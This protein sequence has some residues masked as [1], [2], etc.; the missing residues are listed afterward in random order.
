MSPTS[1]TRRCTANS[2]EG[3]RTRE[4]FSFGFDGDFQVESYLR[5]QG[6]KFVNRFDA[7]SLL[8]ITKAA[9]Y[10]DVTKRQPAAA[11]LREAASKTKYLVISYSSDWL[12]PTYQSKELVQ[13]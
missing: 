8:Y 12:Y 10:F 2:A 11:L 5:H 4:T 7:N 9:D 13:T 6:T 3:C 1:P